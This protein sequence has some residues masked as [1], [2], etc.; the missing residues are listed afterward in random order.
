ML[1]RC[2]DPLRWPGGASLVAVFCVKP[3]NGPSRRIIRR[4]GPRYLDISSFLLLLVRNHIPLPIPR[5]FAASG[6]P[7]W[8]GCLDPNEGIFYGRPF[9]RIDL[10]WTD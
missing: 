10:S 8:P 7:T 5:S 2:S 9:Y 1:F 6:E 3:G 4:R